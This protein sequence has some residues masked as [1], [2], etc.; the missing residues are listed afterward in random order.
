MTRSAADHLADVLEAIKAIEGYTKPG[1]QAFERD[2]MMRDAVAARLMQ[3]G[4][5]VKDAQ[6]EGLELSRLQPTVPWRNIAGMR[7]RL[8]HKYR[9]MDIEIVWGVVENE[10]PKLR[11]AVEALLKSQGRRA[12]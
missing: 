1:R 9:L 7:D 6:G 10:L 5:A 8:V 12:R 2:P 4:Q 11:S 3:I